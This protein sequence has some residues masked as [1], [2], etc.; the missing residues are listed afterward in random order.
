MIQ[1]NIK[2]SDFWQKKET[3]PNELESEA[4][5]VLVNPLYEKYV[6]KSNF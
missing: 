3:F 2:L 1:Y 5:K 6:K 4:W